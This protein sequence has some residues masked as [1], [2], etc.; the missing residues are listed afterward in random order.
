MSRTY[1]I[2]AISKALSGMKPRVEVLLYGSEARGEARQDSDIDILI[3]N[4]Y[5]NY[6]HDIANI[7]IERKM[8]ETLEV[9]KDEKD[10]TAV[11]KAIQNYCENEEKSDLKELRNFL[12]LKRNYNFDV[13][14]CEVPIL[15][16]KDEKPVVAGR[17]DLILKCEGKLGIADIKT[18]SKLDKITP[19]ESR[20]KEMMKLNLEWFMHTLLDRKDRMSMYN[21]LEVRVPFCD[22]RI[23]EYLYQV[24]WEYKDYKG[25]EKGLL[26]E[27]MKEYLPEEVLWRKKSPYPKTHNPSYENAVKAELTDVINDSSSPV[28]QILKKDKS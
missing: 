17:L 7:L 3:L 10:F 16:F 18:T 28:L 12:F 15:I 5:C 9:C 27:A 14:Q 25:R 19:L 2:E 22:Y 21:G 20:M 23:V 24:P 13:E 11:H 1:I 26:R 8:K 4:D 6:F